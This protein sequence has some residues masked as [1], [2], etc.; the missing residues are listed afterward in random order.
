MLSYLKNFI[1]FS[2]KNSDK[3]L[4]NYVRTPKKSK[5]LGFNTRSDRKCAT[6]LLLVLELA[7]GGH[8]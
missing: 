8:W 4:K 3:G 2:N 7:Q 6:A 1:Q 5:V